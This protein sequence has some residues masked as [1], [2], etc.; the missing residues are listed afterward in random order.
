MLDFQKTQSAIISIHTGLVSRNSINLDFAYAALTNV[1]IWVADT[2]TAYLQAPSSEKDIV[3][4]GPEFRLKNVGKK[5]LTHRALYGGKLAG[6]DFSNHLQPC[7]H[8][9]NFTLCTADPDV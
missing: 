9:M 5:A 1:D 2:K 4:C 8:D 3:I 7:M 6:R